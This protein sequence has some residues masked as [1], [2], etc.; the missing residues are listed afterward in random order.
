MSKRNFV[1]C[2]LLSMAMVA[3]CG[4]I[5]RFAVGADSSPIVATMETFSHP[6]GVTYFAACL[7]PAETAAA[8]GP[9][10]V[11]I[12]LNTSAGQVGEYRAKAIEALKGLLAALPAGDRVQL[13]AIDLSAEPL[14]KEFV[15]PQS[16]QMTEA[17]AALEARVPLGATDM[18]KGLN[19]VAGVFPAEAKNPRAVVYIGDGRSAAKLVGTE[20]FTKLTQKLVDARIPVSS[21]IVGGRVDRQLPGAL[22]VQTG[23]GVILDSDA[24]SAAEAGRQL[25]AAAAANVLWPTGVT[26]PAEMTEVFPKRMPPLRGDRETVVFGV[27]K[28]TGPLNV[29]VT[30]EGVGGPQKVNF[31][32][33]P[34]VSDDNNNYLTQLVELGRADGGV[35]LPL[36]GAASLAEA[37]QEVSSGVRNLGALAREAMAG[38]N[39]GGAEQIAAEALR[40][41]PNDAT[42]LAVK[43][44]LAKQAAGGGAAAGVA[45]KADAPAAGNGDLNLV[46][47][48]EPPAGAMAENFEHDRRIIAQMV[49]PKCRIR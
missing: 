45:A 32:I 33:S 28:G 18:D 39:V 31:A 27:V 35:T 41:D 7:K 38:G 10:D 2:A 21:Y 43:G 3:M 47:A 42:A 26:W 36:V 23:G 11:V 6:N 34:S 24:L 12:V 37:R 4:V 19:T 17:L 9:R 40:H 15:A 49:Q 29:Q 20:S 1:R 44:V 8:A 13:M 14:T 5:D 22:A 16:K 46:G 25:A 48:D 30:T